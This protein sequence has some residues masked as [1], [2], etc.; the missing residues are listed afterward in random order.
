MVVSLE[1]VWCLVVCLF[2]SGVGSRVVDNATLVLAGLF[3][4][5]CWFE[6]DVSGA[7]ASA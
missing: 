1:R 4:G 3:D 7:F 5:G 2:V 6:C